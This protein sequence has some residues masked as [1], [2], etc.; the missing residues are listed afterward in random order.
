MGG[1]SDVEVTEVVEPAAEEVPAPMDVGVWAPMR[2]FTSLDAINL[3][4]LFEHR[5]KLMQ[6]V[7]HIL[8]G[9]F[10]MSLG[11][12]Y[13]EILEG[14]EANSEDR[15]VLCWNLSLV[16]PRMLLLRPDRGGPVSRKKLE[17]RV[18]QFQEGAWFSL[19]RESVACAEAAHSSSV[20]RR[21]HSADEEA[22][23]P[24]RALSLVRMGELSATPQALERGITAK[25][26]SPRWG[27]SQDPTR[28]P[29]SAKKCSE[30]KRCGEPVELVTLHPLE[31]L[32]CLRD[33]TPG[34]AAGPSGM[35]SDHLFPMLESEGDSQRL[36][37]VASGACNGQGA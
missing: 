9:A 27:C 24:A 3:T 26:T 37:K 2:A 14:T 10:R 8:R 34:A 19:L 20:R 16:L 35:T 15:T 31:F 11:V 21:R 29:P 7:P 4:D 22:V 18:P 30:S 36:A 28:R 33:S 25:E 1:G 17:A 13:Q 12:A 23:R 5:A 32:I 6:S